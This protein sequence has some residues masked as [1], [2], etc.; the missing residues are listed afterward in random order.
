DVAMDVTY[1]HYHPAQPAT[2]HCAPC[3]RHFGDCCIPLNAEAPEAAPQCPLCRSAL[4]FLGAANTAQP[5]WQRT[6]QF[7]LYGFQAGPLS[8]AA[9]LAL[10]GLFMP[11]SLVL[12]LLLFSVM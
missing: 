1:C 12:R 8:F 11:D 7:F 2:W 10:A 6:G 4:S 3:Q 9:L 5:F